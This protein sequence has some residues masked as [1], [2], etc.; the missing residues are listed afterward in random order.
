MSKRASRFFDSRIAA[1][2]CA[3][4]LAVAIAGIR[5][6]SSAAPQ[7]GSK[8]SVVG[9]EFDGRMVSDLDKSVAFYKAIGFHRS[10]QRG[11]VLAQR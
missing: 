6:S 3:L 2:A 1:V 4:F 8:G 5:Q 11:Q 10:S 7:F 9:I